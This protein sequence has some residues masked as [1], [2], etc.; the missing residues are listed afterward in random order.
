MGDRGGDT[1]TVPLSGQDGDS[2]DALVVFGI[3]GDL[4]TK[5]T[6]RSLYRLEA[7][8]RLQC[9]IHG[10]AREHWSDDT[11]RDHAKMAVEESGETVE[12]R[13]FARFARRLSYIGGDFKD[14]STYARLAKALRGKSRPLFYLE[15]PPV[16]FATVVGALAQ[17]GL[18]SGG[19]RVVIEK[20]FGH[21]LASA[22]QLNRELHAL[23]DERQ[24]LRIDHF[25]GKE[26]VMDI[27]FLRFANALLEPVWNRAHVANVEI[28]LA[29]DFGVEDRGSF[30]DPVG[31]L[32]D[33]VQN[34][35]LQVLAVV[36][37]EPPVAAGADALRD[38]KL[39]VFRAMPEA[40]P[41]RCIRGQYE[42]Y[43]DVPGVAADSATETFVALR[44]E[45]DNWR[46][47]GVPFFLRAGKA[48]AQTATEVRLVFRRPPPLRFLSGRVHPQANCLVLRIEPEPGLRVEMQAKAP[49]GW[50][51]KAVHL[52]MSFAQELGRPPE[53]Y[54]RLLEEA[55]RGDATLFTREDTVEETWRIVQP[56]LDHPSPLEIYPMGSWGPRRADEVIRGFG[57]WHHPWLPQRAA[58]GAGARGQGHDT[59][60]RTT[61]AGGRT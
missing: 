31:A 27:Q 20:P 3:T 32:R 19:A 41:V 26:P 54:E 24:I 44:L 28:T 60:E 39:E 17:A 33:V 18:T 25:L 21:D 57:R 51:S 55:L 53:A 10:V 52:D 36:A 38:K 45:V 12:E 34:H 43:R 5:M 59:T 40:D 29:E 42:G 23:L 11:L 58:S 1:G 37:M 46:W 6:L 13:V 7:R 30:Y 49:G 48:L 56:L 15:I 16:L 61:R 22:R 9:P 50:T 8:G 47:S 35:L 2:S 14:P 4:A